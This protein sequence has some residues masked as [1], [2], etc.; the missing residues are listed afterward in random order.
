MQTLP[1]FML[2]KINSV[3]FFFV[4]SCHYFFPFVAII[5]FFALACMQ[6]AHCHAISV[7]QKNALHLG[8]ILWLF[9]ADDMYFALLRIIA[10]SV[11]S[12]EWYAYGKSRR[13]EPIYFATSLSLGCV[14]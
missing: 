13:P 1:G 14:M 9:L 4:A 10:T 11:T 5:M 8:I 6:L 3:F 2:Q 12:V 7:L